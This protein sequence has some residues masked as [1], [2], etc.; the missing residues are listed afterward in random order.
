MLEDLKNAKHGSVVLLHAC[1]HN[2]TGVDPS[3]DQWAK[4][5]EVCKE[6]H[7]FPFFDVAYQGMVSGS[8]DTDA[9]GM[10]HFLK[11]GLS[12]IV[13]QSFAKNMGLYGERTGAVHFVCANKDEAT[14]VLSQV[15][16]I[17]RTMYSSPPKHG[18]RIAAIIMNTPELREQ[19]Y[20]DIKQVCAR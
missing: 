16:I 10:R 14:R 1:C 6:N 13:A 17:V 18:A 20:Q 15:K 3:L 4:I 5:A 9:A 2:P 19:W 12:F 7:L 11:A 8:L